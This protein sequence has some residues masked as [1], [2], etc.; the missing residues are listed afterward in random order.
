[1]RRRSWNFF[2][3]ATFRKQCCANVKNMKKCLHVEDE[4]SAYFAVFRIGRMNTMSKESRSPSSF[5]S[6]QNLK[7]MPFH[8]YIF[9]DFIASR[10]LICVSCRYEY[11]I[12]SGIVQLKKKAK[13]TKEKYYTK[14][15]FA[16][17]YSIFI[18]CYNFEILSVVE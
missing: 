5:S 8:I 13:K 18:F 11:N 1:M 15:R 12:D 6:W 16:R 10:V 3:C 9:R 17:L 4:V 7:I 14:F 2:S